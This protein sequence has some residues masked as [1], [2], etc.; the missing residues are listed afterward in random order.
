M[1]YLQAD[2]SEN[3]PVEDADAETEPQTDQA[4]TCPKQDDISENISEII[5]M[6][7]LNIPIE[8][9]PPPLQEIREGEVNETRI[10]LI[11]GLE[12]RKKLIR[13]IEN[14]NQSVHILPD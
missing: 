3:G 5:E 2:T 11:G 10:R 13:I 6:Q 7:Y 8:P 12:K 4:T 9:L 1:L 14:R